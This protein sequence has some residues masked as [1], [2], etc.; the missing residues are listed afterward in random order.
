MKYAELTMGWDLVGIVCRLPTIDFSIDD[1]DSQSTE[2]LS[3]SG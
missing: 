2:L 3:K 1:G